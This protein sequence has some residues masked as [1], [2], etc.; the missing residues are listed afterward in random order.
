MRSHSVE[1]FK[2]KRTLPLLLATAAMFGVPVLVLEQIE[3]IHVDGIVNTLDI[4][5]FI[6][7]FNDDNLK[8]S[9][10][11][12]AFSCIEF[13][14]LSK[15][16]PFVIKAGVMMAVDASILAIPDVGSQVITRTLCSLSLIFSVYCIL[17]GIAARHFSEM[18]KSLEF[19]VCEIYRDCFSMLI[20]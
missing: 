11:V 3:N 19:A 6:D 20:R 8:H 5:Q 15:F 1:G 10:L 18:M 12:R 4:R 7:R 13:G 2:R 16:T 9:T 14:K 17:A